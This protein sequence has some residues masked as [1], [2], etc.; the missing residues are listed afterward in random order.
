MSA[1]GDIIRGAGGLLGR[2]NELGVGVGHPTGG[3]EGD[4]RVQMVDNTPRLY[5]LAGGQWY[6]TNLHSTTTDLDFIVGSGTDFIKINS[7]SF[8]R[9]H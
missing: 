2:H 5:A 4:I 9:F 8:P 3:D 6:S 7:M 1:R